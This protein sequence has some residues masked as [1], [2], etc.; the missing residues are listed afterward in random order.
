MFCSLDLAMAYHQV[1]VKPCDVE[2]TAFIT[3][4]GFY[5]MAK[6]AFGLCNAPSAYQRLMAGVLQGLMGRI[7]LS[8]LDNVVVFSTK[9]SEHAANLCAVLDR[10]RAAGLKLKFSKCSLFCDKTLYLGYVISAA[11]VSSYPAKLQVLADWPQPS[12]V[13]KMQ[14][15]LGFI[16]F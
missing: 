2:K 7:C 9:R 16:N 10:I 6:M 14:S 15:C 3:H 11:G 13:R 4:V 1:P 12:S 8:Y 5:E